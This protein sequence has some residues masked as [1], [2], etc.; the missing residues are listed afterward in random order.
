MRLSEAAFSRELFGLKNVNE[1]LVPTA[2][3]LVRTAFAVPDSLITKV[4]ALMSWHL[5][6]DRVWLWHPIEWDMVRPMI[7]NLNNQAKTMQHRNKHAAVPPQRADIS[8]AVLKPR[9]I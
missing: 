7:H 1:W 3:C 8:W 4:L 9:A 5:E 6:T 2:Q